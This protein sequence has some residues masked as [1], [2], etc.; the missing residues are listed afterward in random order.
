MQMIRSIIA[1]L[2]TASVA[3]GQTRKEFEVASIKATG[4]Q[5]PNQLA[6]GVHIDGS[7][8]RM[9]YLSLKDYIGIAYRMRLNQI[10]G[11]D[12]IGSQRF[13][14]AGKLPEGG[15]QSDVAEMVQN[16]LADRF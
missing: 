12:F 14:I 3:L 10:V 16:L 9:T 13:D 6:A 15:S 4:D 5:A 7:Q 8:G 11:P 1:I 2:L